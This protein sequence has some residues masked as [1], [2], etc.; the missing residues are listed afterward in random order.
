[1]GWRR[2]AAIPFKVAHYVVDWVA[3]WNRLVGDYVRPARK[4]FKLVLPRAAISEAVPA[5]LGYKIP[6]SKL[7]EDWAA[8]FSK[9]MEANVMLRVTEEI[10]KQGV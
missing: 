5:T 9:K 4:G 6:P 1:M 8:D 2:L 7:Y 3:A 10:M